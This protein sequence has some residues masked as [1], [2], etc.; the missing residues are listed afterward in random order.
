[1]I[2]YVGH[3]D[4][5][6]GILSLGHTAHTITAKITD[7]NAYKT[8]NVMSGEYKFVFQI[9]TFSWGWTGCDKI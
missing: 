6:P 4:I 3:Q 1:M 5:V 2:H 8:A 9:S 7:C